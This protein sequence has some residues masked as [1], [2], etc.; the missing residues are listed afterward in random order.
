MVREEEDMKKKLMPRENERDR[1]IMELYKDEVMY[2]SA[3]LSRM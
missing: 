3:T 2:N 1:E